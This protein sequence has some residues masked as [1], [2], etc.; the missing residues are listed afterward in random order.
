MLRKFYPKEYIWSLSRIGPE[1]FIHKGIKGVI[2]D[3][4]NTIIPWRSGIMEPHM[5]DLLKQFLQSGLRLCVVSN[6][7]SNRVERLLEPLGIPGIARAVK[8]RRK[9]FRAALNI[10]GTTK[11]ETAVVG[12]Q[13]FTDIFGGNRLGLYTVLVVPMSKKE[14]MG[15]KIV[16]ILEKTLLNRMCKKGIIEIPDCNHKKNF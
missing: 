1:F 16:R 6:A 2:L 15:T 10:M 4:D 5:A 8:P 11:E 9:A 14:F 13:I 7:L 3:L 12:D